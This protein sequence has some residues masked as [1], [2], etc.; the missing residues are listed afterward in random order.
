MVQA[1]PGVPLL[2]LDDEVPEDEPLPEV[3][4]EPPPPPQ[5]TSRST[6]NTSQPRRNVF[7]IITEGKSSQVNILRWKSRRCECQR[8]PT[9]HYRGA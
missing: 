8:L 1:D 3:P 6:P 5:E 2:P 7:M 9:E 4:D